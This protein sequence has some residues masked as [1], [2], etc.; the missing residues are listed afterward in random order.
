MKKLMTNLIA[1]ML[2]LVATGGVAQAATL[3][4]ATGSHGVNGELYTLNPA[5]GS[6]IT[7]VGASASTRVQA[8][9][10]DPRGASL[11]PTPIGSLRSTR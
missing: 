9:S 2:L 1:G 3:Y 11:Q 8:C 7:D 10:M 6:V 5:N 4:A